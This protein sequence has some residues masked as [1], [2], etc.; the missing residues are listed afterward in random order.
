MYIILFL[1]A[2]IS[3]GISAV[4]GGGA[5]FI[6]LPALG[7]L[8]PGL[9]VPAALSIGTAVSS[10][11]RI[12]VFKKHVR[13]D[14]VAWFVPPA[15]PAVW[16][17]AKLLS[18][19]NPVLLEFL[20]GIF[21]VVNLPLIFRKEKQSSGRNP[22]W[23][24][25][26]IGVGTGFISGLTGAVGLLFNRFY[27]TYG[28]SKEEIIATRAANE[29][30]LHLIKI[31]LYGMFGLLTAQALGAGFA[32]SAAA[33]V[34]AWLMKRLLKYISENGFRRTGFIAMVLSGIIM[35]VNSGY[36]LYNKEN[37]RLS[38]QKLDKGMETKLNW[39]KRSF[40]LEFTFDDG[41]EAEKTIRFNDLPAEK[42][43]RVKELQQSG[44]LVLL[45]VVYG[46]GR[47]SYEAYFTNNGRL[48]VHDL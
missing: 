11:S 21:L 39:K 5:S 23:V 8:L 17:G 24:L 41:F 38:M 31:V 2:I 33:I 18:S 35:M 13:W 45:E 27:L 48:I 34:S 9:Q 22:K 28:L 47:T 37:V 20:I 46:W 16:L 42:K 6:L 40:T 26:L 43:L 3:F 36:T 30:L 10:I 44:K 32:L 19:I 1:I 4:C 25:L 7:L 29:L 12:M 15:L 14:I